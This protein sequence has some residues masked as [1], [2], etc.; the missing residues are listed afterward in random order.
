M[1]E[2]KPI[3]DRVKDYIANSETIRVLFAAKISQSCCC[4]R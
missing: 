1:P 2:N 4:T 3:V